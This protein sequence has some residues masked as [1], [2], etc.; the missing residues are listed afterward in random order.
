[1]P[2]LAIANVNLQPRNKMQERLKIIPI[3]ALRP[4]ENFSSLLSSYTFLSFGCIG[5]GGGIPNGCFCNF[6]GATLLWF[7]LPRHQLFICFG[8]GV[9]SQTSPLTY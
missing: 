2:I 3:F 4:N 1:V 7:V 6:G 9:F 5:L 8:L